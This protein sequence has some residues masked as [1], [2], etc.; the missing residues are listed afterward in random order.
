MTA[1]AVPEPSLDEAL[2]PNADAS[3]LLV[4]D[5]YDPLRESSLESRF[6]IS[7]GF[8]GVRG[9]RA[10]TRGSRWIVPARTYVAGLFDTGASDGAVPAL[11]PAAGWLNVHML[12]GGQP[13]APHPGDVT[14]HRITLDMR[15]GALLTEWRAPEPRQLGVR[16]RTARLVSLRER[17]IGL[18]LIQME[19]DEGDVEVAFEAGCEGL[20]VGLV[21][22][23][24]DENL[25]VWRTRQ[26]DIGLAMAGDARLEI[27]GVH[28]PPASVGPLTWS[29]TWTTRP[30]QI[31]SFA[32]LVSLARSRLGDAEISEV[33]NRTL[34]KARG[35]GW[36]GV[37][38]DHETAWA[39]RWRASEV[40]ID[41]DPAAQT[42]LRFALYH[43]NGAANPDDEQVSI[44]ARALTGDDYLGHVFWD[45]E[46]Y[47]LPFY[48]MTWP[49]AARAL[50]M[51][52]F[53][54]LDAARAKAIRLGWRGALYA[55]ES[56]NTGAEASPDHV[57]AP[58]RHVVAILNGVQEQHV[59]ADIAYAVWRYWRTTGDDDFLLAAGAEILL[60]T[61][62]FWA[63]RAEPD[64]DGSRHIRGVIGPD[65]YHQHVDD[66]AF[67]NVMAQWNIRRGL[68]VTALLRD[69]WPAQWSD[70]A[71][72]L[73]LD[74]A[75]LAAWREAADS[76]VTGFNATTGLYE[77]FTGYFDMEPID[78]SAYAGRSA[79]MDMVLGRDRTAA[80]QVIK[81]ADVVALL[82]LLPEA[83]P[84]DAGLKNFLFYEPR[85]G[86]G[87]SLSAAFHGLVAARLGDTEMAMRYFNKTAA[88]DLADTQAADA[89]GVHIAALGG[90]WMMTV[91]GFAGLSFHDDGISLDPR[92]PPG[93]SR[94][95]FPLQWRGRR[96][97]IAIDQPR[98]RLDVILE[99]GEPMTVV[100][101][102]AS[103]PLQTDQ[104]LSVPINPPHS[105]ADRA[106][107]LSET[108]S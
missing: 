56:A 60:E 84:G 99:A 51:Y 25:G 14:A 3:W 38:A 85:C 20:G 30:G 88:I 72:R 59:S 71:L 75:E 66:N 106:F 5:G 13:L 91:F 105:A 98:L 64:P 43:L 68:E 86:Q 79:P 89:G 26:S 27:D 73:S 67:T 42:A 107:Q 37:L 24:V 4:E 1:F 31:V 49:E 10:T 96:L 95:A 34:Q 32:R 92:Q 28:L 81:Q 21:L 69:R 36:R 46:I 108:P 102:G 93:W 9:S 18:Q 101:A 78:L 11:V 48:T 15:R 57:V 44:G 87:S 94:L 58:D 97:R 39:E 50:L 77:Q 90:L 63:S 80:S 83:F 40:E 76:I 53:H 55:W 7:N 61:A 2:R 70:L 17:G 19:L 100:V 35:R 54:T 16:L 6:A 8:L 23:T 47:L 104:S 82:G 12:V 52:R 103:Y 65:E 33:A 22:G 41:G 45:T 29:W 62:R 74:Q